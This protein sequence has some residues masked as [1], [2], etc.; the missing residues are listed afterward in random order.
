MNEKTVKLVKIFYNENGIWSKKITAV[1]TRK[2]FKYKSEFRDRIISIDRLD[3]FEFSN[4]TT[5]P[6]IIV[7][8][9]EENFNS[10][11]VEAKTRYFEHVGKLITFH[12]SII[13]RLR[14][15]TETNV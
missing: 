5:H 12:E 10:C 14:K 11:S 8:C 15:I 7:Y 3:K 1:Q 2:S 6:H 9:L 13:N 4:S